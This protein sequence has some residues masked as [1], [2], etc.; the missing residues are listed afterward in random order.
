GVKGSRQGK[1][2]L[3]EQ[4]NENDFSA[5]YTVKRYTSTKKHS[6]SGDWQHEA[7]R[8]EPLNPE[9]EAFDLGPDAFRVIAEFV[10]VLP[11]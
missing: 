4:F 5:R 2:L 10:T 9:F 8:L 3:I 7:I 6:E 1:R 11:D